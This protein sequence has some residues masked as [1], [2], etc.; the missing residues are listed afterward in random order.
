M[1][2]IVETLQAGLAHHRAGRLPQAESAYRRVLEMHPR[3]PQAMHLLGLVAFQADKHLLAAEYVERAIQFDAFHAPFWADLAEIYRALERTDDAV[4]AY[5]KALKINPDMAD[6]WTHFGTLLEAIGETEEGVGCYRRA[7][8]IDPDYAGAHAFLG[9]AM[10]AQGQLDLAQQSL[11][12]AVKLAPDNPEIYL[13]LGRCLHAQQKWLD[14]IACY[15]MVRR[16][17]PEHAA[18]TQLYEQARAEIAGKS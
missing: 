5:R 9:V 7:L 8:A 6:A 17:E 13:Q 16:I 14:A 18:A 10:Q 3:N 2:D 1:A 11:E 4:A 12:R 15:Q